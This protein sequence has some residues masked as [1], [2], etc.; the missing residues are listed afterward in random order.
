M[1]GAPTATQTTTTETLEE[2]TTTALPI[3]ESRWIEVAGDRFID[4]RTG[5][6]FVPIGV[7]LLRKFGGGGGDRMFA[8]YDPAWVD[9]QLEAVSGFGFNTV[10]FF[11]DMCMECTTTSEG[12]RQ[13]YLDNLADLLVR[14]E[15]HDLVALPTSNDVPD[16]GFS[17]RLPC[18]EP[19]GGYRNSLYLSEE[20]HTIATEY[21]TELIAGIQERGAPTHHLLGWELVNEQFF[22][23]SVPP[24]SLEVGTVTAA[25]RL[26]YDLADDSDVEEMVVNSIRAYVDT[27]GNAIRTADEG[28]LITMGFF[29]SEEPEA[30]RIAS[31][32]RWV[33]PR[34][35]IAESSLDFIDLHGYGGLGGTWDSIGAA[36]G[37]TGDSLGYPLL[38]GEFGAFES[39]YPDHAEA[40]A[41][42]ARWQAES[43][44]FGLGGW[45]VWFWGALKDDEVVTADAG[46]A[47]VARA[48]SPRVRPDPCDEGPYVSD[49]LALGRPV[50]ASAEE[51]GYPAS[52]LTDGSDATWWSA[53]NGPPQW[54]EIDLESNQRVGRVEILIGHVS[55]PG[56]QRHDVYL[57]G[58]GEPAPGTFVGSVDT[59]ADQ[60]DWLTVEFAAVES[61]RYARLETVAMDGWVIL[62]E[63]RVLSE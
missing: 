51:I 34:Q 54:I 47:A 4:T 35:L 37:L 46:D 17:E 55:P 60:G 39:A 58:D 49:N 63:V 36:Y 14:L 6:E 53:E 38:L 62:H 7:N 12:I 32:D 48:L 31:D 10:R 18:C 50:S 24:I 19:F 40:A 59:D 15:A 25:D 11:L 43:C 16:P 30:G 13:D 42:V 26:S 57:R 61:A 9:E 27:V 41:A 8:S 2:T 33:V 56:P 3:A 28:A 21:W 20:G 5:A 29:S 52:H 23:R 44:D 45:L 1:S 22:L